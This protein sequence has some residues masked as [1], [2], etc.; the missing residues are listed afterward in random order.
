MY[1]LRLHFYKDSLYCITGGFSDFLIDAFK[2]KYGDPK[3]ERKVSSSGGIEAIDESWEW[4]TG[5]P[6]V[7]CR[8]VRMFRYNTIENEPLPG[9]NSFS[10]WDTEIQAKVAQEEQ[11]IREHLEN[12]KRQER[13]K[14]LEAL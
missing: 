7:M 13:L 8:A 4:D 1:S 2:L 6:S 11:K 14:E 3:E 5:T 9:V 12:K 10:I